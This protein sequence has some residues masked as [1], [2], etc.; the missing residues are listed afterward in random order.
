MVRR[1]HCPQTLDL[2]A[3]EAPAI[4]RRFEQ[5]HI[6]NSAVLYDQLCLAMSRV[7]RDAGL[8]RDEVA[9]GI[10][11]LL[12]EEYSVDRLNA[13]TAQSK[14]THVINALRLIALIRVTRDIRIL[15][16]VAEPMGYAVIERKWLPAVEAA[17]LEQHE[18]EIAA[19]RKAAQEKVR[20]AM[21]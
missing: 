10:G 17:I 9:A 1:S 21:G 7:L 5:A 8:S 6:T 20:R 3:W 19:R 16:M 18:A 14:T 11:A 12:G 13:D 15:S 4:E 2:L